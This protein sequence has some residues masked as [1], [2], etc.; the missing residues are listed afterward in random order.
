MDISEEI[1]RNKKYKDKLDK[2]DR[3]TV[4]LIAKDHE[5]ALE[6]AHKGIRKNEPENINDVEY[7][8]FVA[9]ALQKLAQ[10]MI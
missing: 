10:K 6:A 2:L 8:E 7:L 1:L 9:D 3:R 5:K 4:V